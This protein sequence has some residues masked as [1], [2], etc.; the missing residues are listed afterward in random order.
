MENEILRAFQKA[1]K[2][3]YRITNGKE[4]LEII[5][6]SK[7]IK[8]SLNQLRSFSDTEDIQFILSV[9]KWNGSIVEFLG[10]EFR[11]FV[12]GVSGTS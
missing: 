8:H 9:S 10:L 7:Q 6:N 1:V 11:G 5:G 12:H 3:N 4:A 2:S